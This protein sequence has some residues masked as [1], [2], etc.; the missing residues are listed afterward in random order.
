[1]WLSRFF[2]FV[3]NR[4]ILT[5]PDDN[6]VTIVRRKRGSCFLAF[7]GGCVGKCRWYPVDRLLDHVLPV[8]PVLEFR[9][10]VG[11]SVGEI[12]KET[13]TFDRGSGV[14]H[15]FSIVVPFEASEPFVTNGGTIELESVAGG[16]VDF[17]GMENQI[18]RVNAG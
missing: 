8:L 17:W 18:S 10:D 15:P 5:I 16:D 1:M 3:V 7:P 9:I 2:G 14:T 13:L 6:H 4:E 11:G 12:C